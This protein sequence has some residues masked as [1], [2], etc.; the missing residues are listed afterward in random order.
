LNFPNG[1]EAQIESRQ[2][3]LSSLVGDPTALNQLFAA[4]M[5]QLHRTAKRLLRNAEDS[6]DA[7]QDAMLSA[8]RNLRQFK[9]RAQF[10]TWTHQILLNAAWS[11][12]RKQKPRPIMSS[13][14]RDPYDNDP[15]F[16]NS[17]VDAQ[18]NPEEKYGQEESHRLVT[19]LVQALPAEYRAVIWHCEME[20]LKVR[21]AAKRLGKPIGTLKSQRHRARKMIL[22]NVRRRFDSKDGDC[23]QWR[24]KS[25]LRPPV[26]GSGRRAHETLRL[27]LQPEPVPEPLWGFSAY[28]LLRRRATWKQIRLDSLV[29]AGHRC[30]ACGSTWQPLGCHAKWS[31]HNGSTTA[32][33]HG[34]SILCVAC[35]IA[36]YIDR[37]AQHGQTDIA[38]KQLSRVNSI[39]WAEAERLFVQAMKLWKERNQKDWQVAVAKSLLEQYPQ[40]TAVMSAKDRSAELIPM[41]SPSVRFRREAVLPVS[42]ER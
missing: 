9:G 2:A 21:E 25:P 36:T 8:F 26:P 1:G 11:I 34:F 28:R 3:P 41:R 32:K 17:L 23:R 39:P 40:L 24:R 12:V 33:L 29:A 10:S 18:P 13:S 5:P 19:E 7:L 42:A 37:S 6:E 27:K 15:A 16:E 38:L 4:C 22:I 14:D 30:S 20:G 31:Y 35:T